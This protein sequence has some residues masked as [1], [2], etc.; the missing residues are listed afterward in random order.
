MAKNQARCL[1]KMPDG[2]P[3]AKP[4][5]GSRRH[6]AEQ[7]LATPVPPQVVTPSRAVLAPNLWANGILAGTGSCRC[8]GPWRSS[9]SSRRLAEQA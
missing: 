8:P 6:A 1:R 7:A 4:P 2:R 5:P 9:S 3:R